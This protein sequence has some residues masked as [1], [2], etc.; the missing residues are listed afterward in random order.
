MIFS[1]PFPNQL[2]IFSV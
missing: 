1:D 2:L